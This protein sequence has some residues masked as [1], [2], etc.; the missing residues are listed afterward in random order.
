MQHSPSN[1]ASPSTS[2][3]FQTLVPGQGISS[4][5]QWPLQAAATKAG[6]SAGS[7]EGSDYPAAEDKAHSWLC[8]REARLSHRQPPVVGSL[9]L[10]QTPGCSIISSHRVLPAEETKPDF[11]LLCRPE[12]NQLEYNW[13]KQQQDLEEQRAGWTAWRKAGL[14]RKIIQSTWPSAWF[15]TENENLPGHSPYFFSTF[16][17]H[18][19]PKS[20]GKGRTWVTGQKSEWMW[21]V[22]KFRRDSTQVVSG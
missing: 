16:P 3:Q 9:L 19:W 2:W 6:G 15:A 5:W 12:L 14:T 20:K 10:S 22:K 18:F 7:R 13:C 11:C 8:L 17:L 21:K 4:W 1:T